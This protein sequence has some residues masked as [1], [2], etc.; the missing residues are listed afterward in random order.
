[1]ITLSALFAGG[2]TWLPRFRDLD[3]LT[4]DLFHHDGR[5]ADRWLALDAAEFELLWR[6]AN[7]PQRCLPVEA[8]RGWAREQGNAELALRRL[9]AKLSAHGLGEV[10]APH[11]EGCLCFAPPDAP[12]ALA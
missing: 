9:S 6:L 2:E 12:A 8:L 1:M 7:A 5:I 11:G 10:L 4:L 3:D